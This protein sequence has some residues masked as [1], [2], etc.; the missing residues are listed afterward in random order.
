MERF[1]TLVWKDR[2]IINKGQGKYEYRYV[3][4][5]HKG[6]DLVGSSTPELMS[7]DTTIEDIENLYPEINFK[8]VKLITVEI[9]EI[10]GMRLKQVKEDIDEFF[11]SKSDEELQAVFDK[12]KPPTAT[13]RLKEYINTLS[14]KELQEAKEELSGD[15]CGHPEE[16]KDN[17]ICRACE[18]EDTIIKMGR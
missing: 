13:N 12:Y 15:D 5:M 8:D 18:D 10:G 2:T 6:F 3:Q 9:N 1:K 16:D 17:G 7:V 14:E 11:D 4:I